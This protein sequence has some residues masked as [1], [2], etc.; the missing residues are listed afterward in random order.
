ME[1]APLQ[2]Y[3]SALLFSPQTS[4]VKRTFSDKLP[5]WI[6]NVSKI[7][8][9]WTSSLQALEGHSNDVKFVLFS[10]DGI[11]LASASRDNTARLWDP[12]TGE[13]RSTLEGHSGG[14]NTIVF[15]PNGS[16]LASAS[17]DNTV[18][19]WDPAT[20]E[21]QSILEGHSCGVNAKVF[22][23]DGSLLAT[24]SNDNTVRLWD[25]ATGKARGTLEGHPHWVR[26]VVFPPD[27]S[28]LASA[29]DDNTVRS[30]DIK[31]S[32]TLECFIHYYPMS[33]HDEHW[34]SAWRQENERPASIWDRSTITFSPNGTQL[35]VAGKTCDIRHISPPVSV[36]QSVQRDALYEIDEER[37]WITWNK[38]EV[39]WLPPNR[40]PDVCAC[41]DGALVIGN[42]SGRMTF[43]YC[44]PA[45]SQS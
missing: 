23:P 37:Q 17:W 2:T 10:P 20:G 22:W 11:L 24:A 3:N 18:R 36:S 13:A 12:A 38:K 21:A 27:G 42:G 34:H 30:W 29:S 14:V 5:K 25:P 28:L 6:S 33:W 1:T 39:L 32:D 8:E 40:R 41:Q 15:S 26:A 4:I 16:L 9:D 35:I 44:N 45:V 43:I 31:S 7:D 19:L